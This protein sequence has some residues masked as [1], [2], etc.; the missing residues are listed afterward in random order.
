MRRDEDPVG[1][2]GRA[3]NGCVV[4]DEGISSLDEFEPVGCDRAA[5]LIARPRRLVVVGVPPLNFEK[6]AGVFVETYKGGSRRRRVAAPR[7]RD[8][9]VA[10]P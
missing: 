6:V 7:C 5:D 2:S 9:A 4:G 1:G 3:G 8:R 10:N